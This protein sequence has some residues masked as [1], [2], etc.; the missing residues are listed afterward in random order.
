MNIEV[1]VFLLSHALALPKRS[2]IVGGFKFQIDTLSEIGIYPAIPPATT[3]SPLLSA[4]NVID[5]SCTVAHLRKDHCTF[6][7][8][9][10]LR[11]KSKFQRV[12]LPQRKVA[13]KSP[14][15][16]VMGIMKCQRLRRPS[17][18]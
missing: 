3:S 18:T 1:V 5:G 12:H 11:R 2:N 6:R 14:L 4:P 16:A 9:R 8:R 17:H 10:R 15:M 13:R 7:P